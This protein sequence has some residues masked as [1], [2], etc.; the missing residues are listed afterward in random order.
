MKIVILDGYTVNPGD[1]DWQ[2]VR[3][4]GEC[5][6][7][8]RTTSTELPDRMRDADIVLTNKTKL[9][10]VAI[11]SA[12]RLRYIG[13]MAT[14][15]DVIDVEAASARGIIVTNVPAY[16]TASTAQGTIALLL[17]LT[18]H[19]GLHDRRVH[20]GHWSR[21]P[22]FCFW[23][24]PILELSGTTLGVVGWGKIGRSV[25]TIAAALGMRILVAS[26]SQHRD[27]SDPD[28]RFVS[29]VDLLTQADVITLHCALTKGTRE[30]IN[31][32][33]LGIMKPSALLLNTARG[34]LIVEKD[35]AAALNSGQIAGAALDVLTTE[36]PDGSSPLLSARNCILTPHNA[37]ASA[38]SRK[39]LIH[40]LAANISAFLLGRPVN[41]VG[42]LS[43]S[44]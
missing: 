18:N 5:T 23:E 44:S 24:K 36:P 27:P 29:L 31:A 21:T 32:D 4:L 19:V 12:P 22:D 17:E 2:P 11:A 26:R 10:K 28:V 30:L 38:S 34:G 3:S 33:T 7:F 39:R 20:E 40:Q 15:Y 41:V 25:A 16:S 42:T 1:L 13:V 37:W 8:D 43:P 9:D 14:G 6:F 35:L